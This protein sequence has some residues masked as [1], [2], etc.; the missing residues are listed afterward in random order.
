MDIDDLN[1]LVRIA[2]QSSISAAARN[3]GITPAAASARLAALERRLGARL[4]HRTTR[5]ATLTKTGGPSC[6]VPST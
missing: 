4:L 2:R 5:M 3:L 6:R 1:L